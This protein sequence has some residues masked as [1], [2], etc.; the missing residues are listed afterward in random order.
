MLMFTRPVSKILIQILTIYTRKQYTFYIHYIYTYTLHHG[1]DSCILREIDY[2][3]A[4]TD[5][6]QFGHA[7]GMC[8]DLVVSSATVYV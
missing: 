7:W 5:V 3:F 6:A 8:F 1:G 4:H 2:G